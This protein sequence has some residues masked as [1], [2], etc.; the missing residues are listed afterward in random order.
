[1]RQSSF[2]DIA[3]MAP[4]SQVAAPV[5]AAVARAARPEGWRAPTL[6]EQACGA[7]DG[8]AAFGMGAQHFCRSH[9]PAGFMPGERTGR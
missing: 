6:G 2:F 5:V 1:M 9:L 7:C 8:A 4:R 3:E